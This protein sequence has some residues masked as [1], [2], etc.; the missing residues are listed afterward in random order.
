MSFGAPAKSMTWVLDDDAAEPLFRQAVDLG[1][2]FGD[3]AN[4]YGL[5]RS[6]EIVGRALKKYTRRDDVVLATKLFHPMHQ[7]PGGSG[8]S[9]KAVMEQV[10]ASLGRLDT[11]YIDLYQIH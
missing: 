3:T 9:R 7:G 11:D 1:I 2:T 8:L 10:D 5:G 6:E 4:I